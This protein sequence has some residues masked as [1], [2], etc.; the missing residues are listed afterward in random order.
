MNRFKNNDFDNKKISARYV[1]RFISLDSLEEFGKYNLFPNV[2]EVTESFGMYNA[3]ASYVCGSDNNINTKNDNVRL[4]VVGDGV[5][6]RTAGLFAFMTK[7]KCWSIDPEL[8]KNN[9]S[10][11]KRL[12]IIHEKIED[13]EPSQQNNWND[14]YHIILMPHSHADIK[15]TWK[16][17]HNNK[18]W[19]LTMPC[20]VHHEMSLPCIEFKDP[21]VASPKNNIKIYSNYCTPKFKI[22]E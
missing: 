21:H 2:K 8:R 12:H 5:T 3:V 16:R 7:W 10:G 19:L 9:Y 6:P 18:T 4:F 22:N 20:C 11:I 14:S 13:W 1:N 15:P 17:L